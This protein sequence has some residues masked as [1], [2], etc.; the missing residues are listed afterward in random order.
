[1]AVSE[2]REMMEKAAT[3]LSLCTHSKLR[4][5]IRLEEEDVSVM[6]LDLWVVKGKEMSLFL[7]SHMSKWVDFTPILPCELPLAR[8][9]RSRGGR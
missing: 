4:V 8:S 5:I 7:S 1:M 9:P 2:P 3:S 6:L